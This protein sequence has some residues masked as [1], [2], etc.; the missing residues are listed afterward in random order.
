MLANNANSVWHDSCFLSGESSGKR[1]GKVKAVRR[2]IAVL[3]LGAVAALTGMAAGVAAPGPGNDGPDA[4]A[5]GVPFMTWWR[6]SHTGYDH[7]AEN[8]VR[9]A[10]ELPR[11][12]ARVMPPQDRP[13]RRDIVTLRLSG[14]VDVSGAK[15]GT[16]AAA[17][18]PPPPLP[19]IE[20][21]APAPLA[22][23]G[24][25]LLGGFAL[26]HRQG[27]RGVPGRA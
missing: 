8:A 18:A 9:D 21:P 16:G 5:G 14:A 19:P 3:L 25:G 27:R 26:L 11:A 1:E 4:S 10:E 2:A 7:F 13:V 15:A 24:P 6:I 12:P 17:D 22:L 23:L 20:V